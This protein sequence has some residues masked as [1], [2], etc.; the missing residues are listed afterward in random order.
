MSKENKMSVTLPVVTVGEGKPT[1]KTVGIYYIDS[2]T[3]TFYDLK[4]GMWVARIK[5]FIIKQFSE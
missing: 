3:A 1:N 5:P 2:Y 4:N